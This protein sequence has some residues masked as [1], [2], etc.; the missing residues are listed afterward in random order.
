MVNQ[1]LTNREDNKMKADKLGNMT[2]KELEEYA[3][4]IIE[5]RENL[6]ELLDDIDEIIN[7]KKEK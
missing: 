3:K 6:S 4:G 1:Y 7:S 5:K 2:I